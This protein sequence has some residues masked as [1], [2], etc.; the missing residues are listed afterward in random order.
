MSQFWHLTL[1][2]CLSNSSMFLFDATTL[3]LL[4]NWSIPQ[5]VCPLLWDWTMALLL[6]TV[7]WAGQGKVIDKQQEIFEVDCL[8]VD[9]SAIRCD[10]VP[11]LLWGLPDLRATVLENLVKKSHWWWAKK[12]RAFWKSFMYFLNNSRAFFS[13][14]TFHLCIISC[15]RTHWSWAMTILTHF[16]PRYQITTLGKSFI[17]WHTWIMDHWK[18]ELKNR[19]QL[20]KRWP[21]NAHWN[22]HKLFFPRLRIIWYH[23]YGSWTSFRFCFNDDW[24]FPLR[25]S[26]CGIFGMADKVSHF[27]SDIKG[28]VL[29]NNWRKSRVKPQ[30][31]GTSFLSSNFVIYYRK[32]YKKRV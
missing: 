26:T 22:F 17:F 5:L 6:F 15:S 1:Q 7:P 13:C 25:F 23:Y 11:A 12:V 10:R 20:E 14:T 9:R 30:E 28:S 3:F 18:S 8:M 2:K 4:I 16:W 27:N 29:Q 19:K 31:I 32:F 21:M 24:L